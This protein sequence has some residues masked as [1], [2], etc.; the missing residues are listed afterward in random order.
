MGRQTSWSNYLGGID[1]FGIHLHC[2]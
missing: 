1:G 2:L